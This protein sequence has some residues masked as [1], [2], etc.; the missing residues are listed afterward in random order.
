MSGSTAT[1]YPPASG[2]STT[3]P[4]PRTHR[5]S[6]TPLQDWPMDNRPSEDMASPLSS[7]G[8]L[9]T[10][11]N[12]FYWNRNHF[13]KSFKN[14]NKLEPALSPVFTNF[15]DPIVSPLDLSQSEW[16]FQWP[17]ENKAESLGF[18]YIE[19]LDTSDSNTFNFRDVEAASQPNYPYRS[20]APIEDPPSPKAETRKPAWG[21]SKRRGSTTTKTSRNSNHKKAN[22]KDNQRRNPPVSSSPHQLR[23]TKMPRRLKYTDPEFP[24]PENETK[25]Q[26]RSH[27]QVEKQYRNR[28]NGQFA[29]LLA[30]I[31]TNII[32]SALDG[33]DGSLPN[34]DK[35]ISKSEVL[36]L[37]K[38]HIEDLESTQ[39]GLEGSRAALEKEAERLRALWLELSGQVIP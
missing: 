35:K 31:P 12:D 22:D 13:D 2:F 38:R 10:P 39:I 25:D 33:S 37:A 21:T 18:P 7:T 8:S 23:S 6:F 28:L 9:Y 5:L 32:G 20:A 24:T 4:T 26:R 16:K 29:T 36:I 14:A 30:V 17:L 11:H 3:I 27:N 19:T 15:G 34:G 1:S